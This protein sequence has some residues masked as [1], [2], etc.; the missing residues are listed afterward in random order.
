M[1]LSSRQWSRVLSE[2]SPS[3]F[4]EVVHLLTE[5][6]II[7][8]DPTSIV[9]EAISDGTLV[10]IDDGS[11]GQLQLQDSIESSTGDRDCT[12]SE[13]PSRPSTN[14][15]SVE[16]LRIEHRVYPETL[17]GIEQWLTW[18][19]TD[20]GRKVPRAPWETGGDRFVS[21]Q[22]PDVWTDFETAQEWTEKLPGYELAF[23]IRDRG[24]YPDETFLLIDY[25]DARDPDTGEIHPIVQEHVQRAGSYADVSTS[26]SGVHIFCCASLP[27]GVKA[28]D[29]ELPGIEGFSDAE[30][31]VYDSARFSAMTGDHLAGTPSE[32]T[33]CQEF[34]DEL[35]EEFA[36]V[37]EGVPEEL[38]REPEKTKS[39][40]TD[41]ETTTDIQDVFDAVQHT[42]PNDIRLRSTVTHE[43]GDGSKS[44]DPSW[45]QSASG[46]RLARVGD[47]WVYRKGMY[48]LDA[49]QVVALEE[50]IITDASAY[51]TGE[52]FW[53]A[54]D[55]LRE[56][57]AHIPEYESPDYGAVS[58]LPL[59]KLSTLDPADR[60][61]AAKK[62]GLDWPP[63]SPRRP[64]CRSDTSRRR[65]PGSR[66]LA[67]LP[68]T[69]VQGRT[70]RSI[71][72]T[73]TLLQVSSTSITAEITNDSVWGSYTWSFVIRSRNAAPDTTGGRDQLPEGL[74]VSDRAGIQR[75]L[76]AFDV[77]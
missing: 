28:I 66:R 32:V 50:R 25:D 14:T 49:L 40:L 36:T 19:P 17:Q 76:D 46:T 1:T 12:S 62:R 53:K 38:L 61:R 74:D 37:A 54:I 35:A 22:D 2:A 52:D 29:A 3:T 39:E 71:A 58:A 5:S 68:R 13:A 63:N 73:R 30:I 75:G 15:A 4:G 45:A 34:V 51:P 10:E 23:N 27:D 65:W 21:A 59:A 55:A 77:G 6:D 9:E 33:A 24:E 26:G 69:K 42:G 72:A 67:P 64:V 18:K 70:V 20:D 31:E 48:G 16:R 57:G 43:R 11:F 8:S 41:V 47:G 60:R 44:L 56:R 7:E